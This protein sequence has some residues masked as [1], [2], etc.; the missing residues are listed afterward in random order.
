VARRIVLILI[1]LL[2]GAIINVIVASRCA[3]LSPLG[4]ASSMSRAEINQAWKRWTSDPLQSD[5]SSGDRTRGTGC[6]EV[7]ILSGDEPWKHG[8]EWGHRTRGYQR[9]VDIDLSSTEQIDRGQLSSLR[10]GWPLP[11]LEQGE[12]SATKGTRKTARDGTVLSTPAFTT[13]EFF[14]IHVPQRIGPFRLPRGTLPT[15]PIVIGFAVNTL[16]YAVI[17]GLLWVLVVSRI[18]RAR[19][20]DSRCPR[21]RY[22]LHGS[23]TAGGAKCPECGTFVA[24]RKLRRPG[25]LWR[26]WMT[27]LMIPPA[28][29]VLSR[30]INY[31]TWRIALMEVSCLETHVYALWMIVL[32]VITISLYRA[33]RHAYRD[34]AQRQREAAALLISIALA[35][36]CSCSLLVLYAR[37]GP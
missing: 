2:V 1:L 26:W 21:C 34:R 18:R 13:A 16:F 14:T 15:R 19:I 30:F 23:I 35:L 29:I 25:R 9:P 22:D 4:R 17:V 36:V 10:A 7:S 3:L 27:L 33:C 20:D 32:P 11:C 31:V 28:L 8:M 37:Y 5:L 6:E 24:I 12:Y